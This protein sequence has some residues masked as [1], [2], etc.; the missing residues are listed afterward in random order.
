M[1]S[2]LFTRIRTLLIL[3]FTLCSES[4]TLFPWQAS[5]GCSW[6]CA[7]DNGVGHNYLCFNMVS[8]GLLWWCSWPLQVGKG[9]C[10]IMILINT[11]SVNRNQCHKGM[12]IMLVYLTT[13][14]W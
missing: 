8:L 13:L 6:V 5:C 4:A 3:R 12:V 14:F 9:W 7:L 11:F 1:I 2:F 10:L